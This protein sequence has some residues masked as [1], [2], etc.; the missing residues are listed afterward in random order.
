VKT[1]KYVVL[2][3]ETLLVVEL[4]TIKLTQQVLDGMN[5]ITPEQS[6]TSTLVTTKSG[7]LTSIT[8]FIKELMLTVMLMKSELIGNK[9]QENK[10]MSQLLNKKLYGQ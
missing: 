9:S 8:K 6:R 7:W 5:S 4:V 10:S 2:K 1:V 3:M